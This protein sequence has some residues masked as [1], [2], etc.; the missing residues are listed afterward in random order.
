MVYMDAHVVTYIHAISP[1][2]G[3]FAPGDVT[4]RWHRGSGEGRELERPVAGN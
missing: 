2:A 1:L 4:P 3:A